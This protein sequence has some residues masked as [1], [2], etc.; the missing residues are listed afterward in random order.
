[1]KNLVPEL[2]QRK[3]KRGLGHPVVPDRKCLKKDGG[4]SKDKEATVKR[5]LTAEAGTM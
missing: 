4:V 5:L 2:R 1:M 3:Y